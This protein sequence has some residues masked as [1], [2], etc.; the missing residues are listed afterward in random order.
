[1]RMYTRLSVWM[2]FTGVVAL[3]F[4]V[5]AG[6]QATDPMVGTWKLNVAKSTYKP[7]PPP[8][9][10]T[11]II[12]P[13]GKGIKVSVDTVNADGTPLKWGF[14]TLRDGKD[15]PVTGNPAY[16][17]A[18]STQKTPT[19]GSTIYKKDGKAVVTVMTNVSADGKTLT[20]TATGTDAKGQA[21]N[22]V[23]VY[24]K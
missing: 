11:A 14:T 12:E 17:T 15:V 13:A 7:G 1:M 2:A 21:I 6:A 19:S 3:A 18:A 5:T 4:T 10:S 24:T 16:D 20:V 22:N 8:K 9:S 23:V